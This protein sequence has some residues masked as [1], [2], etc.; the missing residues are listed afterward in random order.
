MVTRLAPDVEAIVNAYLLTRS[1]L[2]DVVGTRIGTQLD[3]TGAA[4]LPALRT[5]IVSTLG[6]VSRHLDAAGV[7]L[8]GWAADRI[9]ARDVCAIARA[10]LLEDGAGSILGTHSGLGVVT[11]T[12]DGTGPR[13]QPDP[14]TETPRWLAV[15]IVYAH[16]LPD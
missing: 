9:T 12:E 7:Q 14:Q 2:T 6:V 4:A 13:P 15:V 11:G 8:E 10:V 16:P 3:L 1:E 5:G